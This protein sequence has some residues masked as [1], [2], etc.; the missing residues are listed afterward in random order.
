MLQRAGRLY[1]NFALGHV[2]Y[3]DDGGDSWTLGSKQGLGGGAAAG[4][5]GANEDQL[6]ELTNGTF[7]CNLI[8]FRTV[9]VVFFGFF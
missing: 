8:V 7:H 4:S 2:I 5:M 9:P 3:S 6:A 1:N